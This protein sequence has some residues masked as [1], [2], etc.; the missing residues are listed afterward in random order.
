MYQQQLQ[1]AQQ[2]QGNCTDPYCNCMNKS[3]LPK[4]NT[5][6]NI[7]GQQQ[8]HHNYQQQQQM[9][10]LGSSLQKLSKSP[11]LGKVTKQQQRRSESERA[12]ERRISNLIQLSQKSATTSTQIPSQSQSQAQSKKNISK[13]LQTGS[14]INDA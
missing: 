11:S 6:H 9:S 13:L 8:Q 5:I 2:Q 4:Y 1:K 12:N 10:N 7:I 3:T 14:L